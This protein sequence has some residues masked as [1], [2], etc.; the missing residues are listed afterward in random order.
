MTKEDLKLGQIINE[1]RQ[2]DAIHVAVAPVR[3]AQ[4]LLPGQH[5]GLI[6]RGNAELVGSAANKIGIVDPYLTSAVRE[7]ERFWLFLYPNTVTGLRHEWSHPLF[8][9]SAPA[10]STKD[11]A[12]RWLRDF[13]ERTGIDYNDLIEAMQNYAAHGSYF[14]IEFDTPDELYS[15]SER[16]QMWQAFQDITGV[17]L[18]D[19]VRGSQPFTCAC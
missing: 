14:T 8:V 7:G 18:T 4:M 5:V 19:D 13:G 2:R 17:E 6:E 9:E 11:E 3:A 12:E 15:E 10:R 16:S 1:F